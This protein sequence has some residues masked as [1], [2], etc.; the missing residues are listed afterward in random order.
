ML[1]VEMPVKNTAFVYELEQ[2]S[3]QPTPV[4]R[5]EMPVEV[6]KQPR[7]VPRHRSGKVVEVLQS[8]HDRAKGASS[9]ITQAVGRPHVDSKEPSAIF[10][11]VNTQIALRLAKAHHSQAPN[12][13]TLFP[14][15]RRSLRMKESRSI[16]RATNPPVVTEVTSVLPPPDGPSILEEI[17][18][19]IIKSSLKEGWENS[20]RQIVTIEVFWRLRRCLQTELDDSADL[21]STLTITGDSDHSWA[22]SCRE[23]VSEMWPE[24]GLVLLGNLESVLQKVVRL[25]EATTVSGL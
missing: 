4:L 21:S 5:V 6:S 19:A 17:D 9:Y 22:T 24:F 12:A 25:E 20:K 2:D 13:R 18:N 3:E 11:N 10:A 15:L 8:L 7:P 14:S 1:R 23:Y 16:P